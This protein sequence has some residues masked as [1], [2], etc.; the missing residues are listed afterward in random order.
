M[1]N[2]LIHRAIQGLV[3]TALAS[4]SLVA[5][6]GSLVYAYATPTVDAAPMKALEKIR[7]S[8]ALLKATEKLIEGPVWEFLSQQLREAPK[9]KIRFRTLSDGLLQVAVENR[10][11]TIQVDKVDGEILLNHK[12]VNIDWF[13]NPET[14]MKKLSEA[15]PSLNAANNLFQLFF[16]EAEA[17]LAYPL[18]LAVGAG[19]TVVIQNYYKCGA[20]ETAYKR[21]NKFATL[22]EGKETLNDD[23]SEEFNRRMLGN[24]EDNVSQ[25]GQALARSA[26]LCSKRKSL[27]ACLTQRGFDVKRLVTDPSLGEKARSPAAGTAR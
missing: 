13:G 16:S 11:I 10:M 27:E 1:V 18:I 2:R 23:S 7:D 26:F 8:K 15:M 6:P 21:C 17:A 22:E 5:I 14:E 3:V 25:Y 4:G 12:K 20:I 9:T 19:A 24:H